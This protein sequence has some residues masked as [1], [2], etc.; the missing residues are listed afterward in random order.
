VSEAGALLEVE[1]A[2]CVS[3]DAAEPEGAVEDWSVLEAGA[4][5]ADAGSAESVDEV[6]AF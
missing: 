2:G 6:A 5:L 1:V 3:L 4:K